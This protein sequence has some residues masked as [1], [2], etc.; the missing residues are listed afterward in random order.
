MNTINII[1]LITM[2]VIFLIAIILIIFKLHNDKIKE[3]IYKIDMT[4]KSCKEKIKEKYSIITKIIEELEKKLKTQNKTFANIK[5][6]NTESV[7]LLKIDKDLTICYEE[8][9]NILEDNTNFNKLKNIK[10]AIAKYEENELYIISLR[11][12]YN[13]QIIIYN[14]LINK[15]PYNIISYMKKYKL[16]L[17]FEGDE[18]EVED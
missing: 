16:K 13:K 17:L 12:Y 8:I 9:K 6:I 4:E 11:T 5:N 10:N 14:N 1:I 18:I 15:F 7:N 2:I 3:I